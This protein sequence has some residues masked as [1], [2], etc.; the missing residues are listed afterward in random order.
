MDSP[1]NHS[2]G[3]PPGQGGD[4]WRNQRLHAK[5]LWKQGPEGHGP[6]GRSDKKQGGGL[7]TEFGMGPTS[8]RGRG[9]RVQDRDRPPN[10][11]RRSTL[12]QTEDQEPFDANKLNAL[13]KAT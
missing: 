8:L 6:P 2:Q 13:L 9:E 7:T 10:A 3:Y 11:T 4:A 5:R 1:V 12:V